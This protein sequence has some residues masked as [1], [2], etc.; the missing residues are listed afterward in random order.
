[1]HLEFTQPDLF[2]SSLADGTPWEKICTA[3]YLAAS[4]NPPHQTLEGWCGIFFSP[5]TWCQWLLQSVTLFP[6]H[7]I[8]FLLLFHSPYFGLGWT[9]DYITSVRSQ[10]RVF[11]LCM[12]IYNLDLMQYF[13]EQMNMITSIRNMNMQPWFLPPTPRCPMG[14]L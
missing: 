5:Y 10:S 3:S 2:S 8:H 13:W 11:H 7:S 6:T 9:G 14:L 1:M 4:L 12:R